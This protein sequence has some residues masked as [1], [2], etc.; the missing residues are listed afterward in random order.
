MRG[1]TRAVARSTA[2]NN[3]LSHGFD[4]VDMT[5]DF[6]EWNIDGSGYVATSKFGVR[7][8]INDCF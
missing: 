7:A 2:K 3:R 1:L 6:L 4:F 8:H 5:G